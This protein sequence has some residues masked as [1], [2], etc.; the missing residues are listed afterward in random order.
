MQHSAL[1]KDLQASVDGEIRFSDGDR[2]LY[3][4]DA[5]NYRQVPVGVVIPR[6]IDDLAR[7]VNICARHGVPILHRGAGTSLAG[8]TVNEHAVIIDSSKYCNHIVSIDPERRLATVEPGC[9]LDSLNGETRKQHDLV[10]GADPATHTHCTLGGVIGNNS[11]GVHALVAG[12]ARENVHQLEI[13]TYDGEHMVVGETPPE[14][15]EELCARQDRTGQIYRDLRALRDRYADEIRA[16]SPDIPRRVSG[17]SLVQLLP[18]KNFHVARALVGSEGTC[19]NILRATVNLMY[20]P[21]CKTMLVIGWDDICSAADAVPELLGFDPFGLEAIDDLLVDYIKKKKLH[22]DYLKYLPEGDGWLLMQFAAD[23][24]DEARAKA[25][26]VQEHLKDHPRVVDTKLHESGEPADMAIWEIRESGLGATAWVYEPERD[27]WPGWEDSAVHPD[28][29]GEYLRALKALYAK[30]DYHGAMYGHFGD[31]LI[32]TRVDFGLHSQ[33]TVARFH[34]FMEE[35]AHLVTRMGG[36]LSGEHGD[37]QARSQLLRI[38]YGDRMVEAFDAFKHIWDPDNKMNPHDVVRPKKLDEDLR[39]GPHFRPEEPQTMFRYPETRNSFIR[40]TMRCVGVG[41]CRVVNGGTMCPSYRGT[42]EEKHST[43]GRARLFQEV[44][45]NGPLHDTWQSEELKD[46]LDLCL[47]CKACRS[48]CPVNVDMATYKSEFLYQHY[49][50]RRRPREDLALGNIRTWAELV[51]ATPGGSY[52]ANTIA[53][54][55]AGK[56]AAGV[57]PDRKP[58]R[59]ARKTFRQ[60]W[61]GNGNGAGK[62]RVILWTDTFNNHF[63]PDALR[64]TAEVLGRTGFRV[65][66]TEKDICCGR[67]YYDFGMLDQARSRLVT[68]METLAP[69]LEDDHTWIVGLEPSCLTV[70]HH[71]L[72]EMFPDD[73]RAHRLASRHL[74]VAQFLNQCS[75]FAPPDLS[76]R[77]ILLHGHCHQKAILGMDDD[78]ELLRRTGAEV[79]HLDT[80]CCGMAGSF[81]YEARKY[82][83]SKTIANQKFLPT[84]RNR[85]T[86]NSL[87]VTNGFSCRHQLDDLAGMESLTLPEVLCMDGRNTSSR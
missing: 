74:T 3:A 71:E 65:E 10:F 84:I 23:T 34:A 8:Q 58:P 6:S 29:L 54:T 59:F 22:E 35:A 85:Q 33:E 80:G 49:R 39:F 40:S 27:T 60:A 12:V 24:A 72:L 64:A 14:K 47:A 83:L 20:E 67:P 2:A 69:I 57:H 1:E 17:Y 82:E 38:M 77:K 55:T 63:M 78:I 53:N 21:P 73:E 5:S 4:N 45:Q 52:M 87:V 16:R 51:A 11:G 70:F 50:N 46:A 13:M 56:R 26:K 15:L 30:Y 44:F 32:H 76:D 79:E 25:E 48:E 19:V 68:L 75:D 86:A 42:L 43:R 18:E 28:R 31:G 66:L 9:I 7:T 61:Q 62:G 37:G 36:T 41:K 81:G